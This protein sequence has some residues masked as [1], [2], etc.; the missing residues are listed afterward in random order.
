MCQKIL[1]WPLT[2]AQC[3]LTKFFSM[4]RHF[5]TAIYRLISP[6]DHSAYL[7]ETFKNSSSTV[8]KTRN[9]LSL[10]YIFHEIN[11]IRKDTAG[12]TKFWK[13]LNYNILFLIGPSNLPIVAILTI[14][15]RI[16][17][18]LGL[19]LSRVGE[20]FVTPHL[21]TTVHNLHPQTSFGKRGEIKLLQHS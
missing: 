10:N 12:F 6:D 4:I 3:K 1:R 18:S 14:S 2:F 17:L 9:F 15:S 13:F 20:T 21:T 19:K 7:R 8:W 5:M 16:V 11:F